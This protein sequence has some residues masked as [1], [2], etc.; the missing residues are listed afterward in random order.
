MISDIKTAYQQEKGRIPIT[1][2]H[3]KKCNKIGIVVVGFN[4]K[5]YDESRQLHSGCCCLGCVLGLCGIGSF[6][7]LMVFVWWAHFWQAGGDH[8]GGWVLTRWCDIFC[9]VRTCKKYHMSGLHLNSYRF[10][11]M[12][13]PLLHLKFLCSRSLHRNKTPHHITLHH[14]TS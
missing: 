3:N 4:L 9:M 14:I 6:V 1:P 11:N 12:N 7:S 13:D 5:K 2:C 10:P 8:H